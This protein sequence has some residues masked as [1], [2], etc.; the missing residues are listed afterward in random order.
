MPTP[1]PP[2]DTLGRPQAG[3]ARATAGPSTYG[4]PPS[5]PMSSLNLFLVEDSPV[6]RRSLVAAL[7]ELAPVRVVGHAD[8]APQALAWLDA[9][10]A[11]CDLVVV[12]LFLREG[13]GLDVLRRLHRLDHPPAR[14]V[15]SNYANADLRRQ[16]EALGAERVFDKSGDIDDL[17]A[18]CQ[19]L[20]TRASPRP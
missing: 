6:I 19:T 12:D 10:G 1:Q 15:L 7:E 3:G 11:D 13:S 4:A 2:V 8:G 17:V 18:Y 16:C 14:V 20:A 9:H 5:A